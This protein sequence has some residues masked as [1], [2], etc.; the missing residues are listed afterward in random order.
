M[1]LLDIMAPYFDRIHCVFMYFVKDLKHLEPY[2]KWAESYP[3]V[4]LHQYPHWMTAHYIKNKV[5]TVRSRNKEQVK[6][7]DLKQKHIEEKA[8]ERTGCDWIVFGH[9]KSDS[10]NRR[11]MLHGYK[12][13]S[14]NE[15]GSKVYPL[16]TWSKAHVKN[17][18]QYKNIISPVEYGGKNSNGLDL[19]VDVFLYLREHYPSDLE[20]IFKVFPFSR[21]ILFEYDYEQQQRN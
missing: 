14:I 16:S 21:K 3:N 4:I 17:Y 10:L 20:K 8:R 13:D 12:F 2:L 15:P 7:K 5:Y 1:V 19:N 18:L 6:V 11:L 9:K